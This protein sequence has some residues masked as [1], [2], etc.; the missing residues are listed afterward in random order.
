MADYLCFEVSLRAIKPRIWRRFLLPRRATFLAL[1]HAIQACGWQDYH[2]WAFTSPHDR[3]PIAGPATDMESDPPP[4]AGKVKLANYFIE[5]G[6]RCDYLYDFGDGWEHQVVF[7]GEVANAEDFGRRLL[8]GARRFPPEDCGGVPGYDRIV[9]VVKTGRDPWDDAEGLAEWIGD[10]TPD[11][12][13]FMTEAK[14]FEIVATVPRGRR[15]AKGRRQ[16]AAEG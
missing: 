3:E 5:K 6:D 4:D 9:E 13:S 11:S 2:L 8:G 14:Q 16:S 1:H 12:F 10:W 7:K 15:G